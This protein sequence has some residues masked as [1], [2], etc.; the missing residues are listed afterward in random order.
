MRGFERKVAVVQNVSRRGILELRLRL[1]LLESS[2]RWN[3]LDRRL[4]PNVL[5]K[6]LGIGRFYCH[7]MAN[8]IALIAAHSQDAKL[9]A[10]RILQRSRTSVQARN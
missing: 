5:F 6:A 1:G 8:T 3:T 9:Q 2:G 4:I 7:V 10:W